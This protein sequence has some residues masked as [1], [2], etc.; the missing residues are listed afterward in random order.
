MLTALSVLI[1]ARMATAHPYVTAAYT[2]VQSGYRLD[3]VLNLDQWHG[4]SYGWGL[5]TTAITDLTAATG[6]RAGTDFRSTYWD[7]LAPQYDVP[8]G[9]IL[10]GSAG[11]F[12]TLPAQLDYFVEMTGPGAGFNGTLIPTPVPEPSS[13]LAL[14]GGIAG[15]GGL[16]MRRRRENGSSS[17]H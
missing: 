1:L 17:V 16:A 3:F 6:W 7:S 5:F 4:S 12:S 2:P 10:R 9:G 15:L 8:P 14:A 13:I 11:T